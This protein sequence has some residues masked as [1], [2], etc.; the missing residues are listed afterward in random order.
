MPV[1][2]GQY[3]FFLKY[4]PSTEDY[5][6]ETGY[7]LQNGQAYHLDSDNPISRS[8]L[9][10]EPMSAEEFISRAKKLAEQKDGNQ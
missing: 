3:L 8:V 4:D 2:G 1:V 9:Q 7:Q 5:H 6:V 10:A